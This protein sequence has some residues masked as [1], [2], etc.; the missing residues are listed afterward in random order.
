[1][2]LFYGA[3]FLDEAITVAAIVGLVLIL[4]GVALASRPRREPIPSATYGPEPV[5]GGARVS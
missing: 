4:G 2:A 5:A 1:V 3:V